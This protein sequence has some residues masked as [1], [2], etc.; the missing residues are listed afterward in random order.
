MSDYFVIYE[1]EDGDIKF[2]K[3]SK[4][5]LGSKLN[6]RYWGDVEFST[7][8]PKPGYGFCGRYYIIKGDL[9]VPK[10]VVKVTEYEV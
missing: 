6:A 3:Y 7:E 10:P 1:D 8:M 2:G 5:E 4:E 9:I